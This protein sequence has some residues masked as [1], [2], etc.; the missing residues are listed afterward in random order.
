[1]GTSIHC[2]IPKEK[3]FEIEELR[4]RLDD[5]FDRLKTEVLHLRE[6]GH[7]SKMAS[8]SGKWFL[9][10]VP[11][12]DGLPEHITG[13]GFTFSVDIYK[14]VVLIGCIERF[15]DLYFKEK[16]TSDQ[17]FK[18]ITEIAK[19]FC[20]SNKL[21]LAAGGFGD[22]DLAIDIAYDANF[23]EICAKMTELHGIPADNFDDLKDVPWYLQ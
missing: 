19:E 23:D 13:E 15:N 2:I 20:Y 22:T 9:I 7:F 8:G 17:L 5:V 10:F 21:L 12:E 16:N 1:M 4:Q 11:A 3:D 6:F 18:I 14:N